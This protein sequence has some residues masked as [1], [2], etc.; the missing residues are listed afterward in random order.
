MSKT[1]TLFLCALAFAGATQGSAAERAFS[2]ELG[3]ARPTSDLKEYNNGTTGLALG[4][5]FQVD[6]GDGHLL[7]PRISLTRFQETTG[8]YALSQAALAVDY[9]YF[10]E[11]RAERG[12][13]VDGGLGIASNRYTCSTNPIY[14]QADE[15]PVFSV[16]AGYQFNRAWGV[17]FRASASKFTDRTTVNAVSNVQFLDVLATYRF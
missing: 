3:L 1:S 16:G 11:G 12:F 7:R 13:Y 9:L 14:A 17:E 4:G 10:L 15:R 5:A 2:L 6:L 8:Y